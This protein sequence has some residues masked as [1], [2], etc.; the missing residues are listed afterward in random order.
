MFMFMLLLC[1][2]NDIIILGS[3]EGNSCVDLI[4]A[5]TFNR[6]QKKAGLIM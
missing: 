4:F 6:S 3:R 5:L 1:N 2:V